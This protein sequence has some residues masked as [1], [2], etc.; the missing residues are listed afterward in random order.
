ML[1]LGAI[2]GYLTSRACCLCNIRVYNGLPYEVDSINI[3]TELVNRYLEGGYIRIHLRNLVELRSRPISE[4]EP[5]FPS[6]RGDWVKLSDGTYGRVVV[7]TP[8]IVKLELIGGACMSY[9][10]A[11]YLSQ[12]PMNLSSGFRLRLTFGLDYAH[13]AIITQEIPAILEKAIIDGL[14][15]EGHVDSIETINVQF[16]EAGP[17]SLDLA[18]L[19]NFNGNAQ[20]RY[21]DLNRTIQRI[22]VDTCNSNHWVIPFQQITLHVSEPPDHPA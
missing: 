18:I 7:Q 11:D 17:S 10:T 4:D 20:S 2:I 13:Q 3:Y 16:K 1:Q 22:C 14:T 15:A 19:A 9:K 6:R 21:E 5:W 8:E 12:A